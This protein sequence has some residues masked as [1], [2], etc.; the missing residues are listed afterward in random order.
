MRFPLRFATCLLALYAAPLY[1]APPTHIHARYDV[2]D[3]GLKVA[4]IDETFSR[5]GDRYHIESVTRPFGLFA[6]L[7]HE[8]IRVT[9]DGIVTARGLQPQVFD[10]RREHDTGKNAHADFDWQGAKITLTDRD[11]TRSLPLPAGT[12]DRLSAMYQFMFLPLQDATQLEFEMTN[13]SKVDN[14]RYRISRDRKVTVPLGSFHALYLVS[15]K[16]NTPRR[17]EIWLATAR[18][19]FPCRM[20]ITET[21][22][23]KY[24]QA[25][26]LFDSA[27]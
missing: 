7:K 22:G 3:S 8:T 12:Q 24:T 19:N 1:A 25:L 20:D 13:G 2:S 9:S 27:P 21:N 17:T 15:P 26:T 18:G 14:Y 4:V 16:E 23:N 11:G 10:Y 6:L 5:S